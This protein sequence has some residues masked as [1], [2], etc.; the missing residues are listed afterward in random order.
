M[1]YLILVLLNLPVILLAF[2]NIITQYKLNRIPRRNLAKQ[3]LVWSVLL[4]VLIG[5]FPV[6]N[7]LSGKDPLDSQSLSAFDIVQTT[8]IVWLFYVINEQRRKLDHTERRLR[9]LHQELS[10]RLSQK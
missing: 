8:A 5:S 1:R 4:I 2:T 10:I 7:Y 6:Y 9:E 3:L